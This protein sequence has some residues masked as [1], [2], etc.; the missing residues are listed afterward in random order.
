M[1]SQSLKRLSLLLCLILLFA[2]ICDSPAGTHSANSLS[3]AA[4]AQAVSKIAFIRMAGNATDIYMVAPDGSGLEN[5]TKGRLAGISA[6]AWS[7]DGRQLVVSADRGSNLYIIAADGSSLRALTHNMGFAI[8]QTP[9]WS[10]DGQQIA[11][12]GNVAQN[13]DVFLINP[14]GTNLRRLTHTNSIYRDLAWSPDGSRIA[15]ASGPEFFNVRIHTMRADGS[16]PMQVSTGGGSDSAPAWSPD[17]KRIAY[18]NDYQFGSPKIFVINADGTGQTRLTHNFGGDRHPTWSP[19]GSRIAFVSS[20]DTT[21]F[22]GTV[23]ALYVMNPDGSAPARVTEL[24]LQAHNPVWQ[25]HPGVAPT[26][27]APVLITETGTG[28]AV[29]LDSVTLVREPLPLF[30]AHN[31][32]ADRCTR[33]LLFVANVDPAALGQSAAVTVRLADREQR[34]I[35]LLPE[36]INA[37]PQLPGVAQLTVRLPGLLA[38]GEVRVA[39]LANGVWSNSAAFRIAPSSD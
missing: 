39:I 9:T 38:E 13:Y 10:P 33:V 5:I 3:G 17:G 1:S 31:F 11:Y 27:G 8:T 6:F 22:G 30:T 29:A 19:D 2:L 23:S 4:N 34:I 16:A 21:S 20:R 28:R 32:S 7:P 25:P 37:V 12:I 18:Q 26:P 24:S 35:D 36:S 14:D 15:Y